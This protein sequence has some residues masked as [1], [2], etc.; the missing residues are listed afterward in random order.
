MQA[1]EFQDC[2]AK[3]AAL[4][5]NASAA[6]LSFYTHQDEMG[7]IVKDDNSPLTQADL[8]ADRILSQ[9]LAGIAD[10]PVISEENRASHH[11]H[12]DD[13][14]LI[15]PIDGTKEFIQRSGQ[16]CIAIARISGRRPVLGLIYSPIT[17]QYWYAARG[18]GAY[19]AGPNQAPQRLS[20]RHFDPK[21]PRLLSARAKI[22]KRLHGFLQGCFGDYRH[23]S[24]ASALK[25]CRMAEG[26]ADFYVKLSLGGCE[27]D[28]AAG[29]ILLSEA[30]G[31]MR[32]FADPAPIAYGARDT[33]HNP[34]FIAYG[35]GFDAAA[36]ADCFAAMQALFAAEQDGRGPHTPF[37]A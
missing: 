29:D 17:Q 20:C 15:D 7:I 26:E 13:Y 11:R 6:I 5:A 28:I 32:Y 36:I 14:W 18:M 30:G 8:A 16:F 33:L 31:G 24:Q 1:L 25:Y 21:Q 23:I 3:I 22:S 19:K 4:C 37:S 27:W 12:F 35:Q 9:G 2:I 10:I 34:P